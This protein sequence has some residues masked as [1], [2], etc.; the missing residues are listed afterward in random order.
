MFQ[1]SQNRKDANNH[2]GSFIKSWIF[3]PRTSNR[4]LFYLIG[5][6]LLAVIF[7]IRYGTEY[8][9]MIK[10]IPSV[11]LYAIPLIIGPIVN[12]FKTR[13]KVQEWTLYEQGYVMK[14]MKH[15]E[16]TG[17]QI[18]GYWTDFSHCT[19]DE[20]GVKLIS[21]GP[22]KRNVRIKAERNV[23]EIYSVCRER[24]SIV[25][26]ERLSDSSKAPGAPNTPEQ[27]RVAKMEQRHRYAHKRDWSWNDVFGNTDK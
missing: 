15:K 10:E 11:L 4:F 27:R 19:F 18:S 24:I 5:L 9:P 16:Y 14:Y 26:A 22:A 13:G 17:E 8:L 2:L 20:K 23:M 7:V 3:T 25:Q 6:L 21:A 12:Y 1:T